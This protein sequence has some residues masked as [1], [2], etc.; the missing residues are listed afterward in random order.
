MAGVLSALRQAGREF[1]GRL[2]DYIRSQLPRELLVWTSTLQR[3]KGTAESLKS[4]DGVCIVASA[5][6][7][8]I[9]A[10]VCEGMTYDDVKREYPDIHKERQANKLCYRYP[11]GG[12][13]Y[14]DVCERVKPLI[15]ELERIRGPVLIIA[16]QAVCRTLL[17]KEHLARFPYYLSCL[18]H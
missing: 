9:D 6:L 4:L 1:S 16:H 5:L 3:T 10:G 8:E 12:E 7:N 17:G 13:S 2:G 11:G 14:L 15:L 18:S